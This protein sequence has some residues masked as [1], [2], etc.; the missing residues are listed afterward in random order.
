MYLKKIFFSVTVRN[1]QHRKGKKK[2]LKYCQVN[3][4][5]QSFQIPPGQIPTK[6]TSKNIEKEKLDPIDTVYE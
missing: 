3:Y 4:F 6:K 2:H 1:N 5:H